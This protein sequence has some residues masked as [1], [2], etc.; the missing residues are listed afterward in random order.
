VANCDTL[1][2]PNNQETNTAFN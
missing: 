1:E 2:G